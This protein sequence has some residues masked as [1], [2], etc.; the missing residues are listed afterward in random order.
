MATF[1]KSQGFV[2]DNTDCGAI[3]RV[4]KLWFYMHWV[5]YL[6]IV[7]RIRLWFLNVIYKPLLSLLIRLQR[8]E[9]K[10]EPQDTTKKENIFDVRQFSHLLILLG[11]KSTNPLV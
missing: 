8:H 5:G 10:I 11:R 9:N 4:H 1:G 6:P 2:E 3:G 7:H